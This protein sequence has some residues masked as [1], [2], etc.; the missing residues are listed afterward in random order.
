MEILSLLKN[1]G[2]VW[3]STHISAD[4]DGLGS[5]VAFYHALKKQ[6]IPVKI[7]HNDPYPQRYS[8]LLSDIEVIDSTK[9]TLDIFSANDSIFIFD[10]HDPK[11]CN[12]LFEKIQQAKARVSF[13]DHH[14]LFEKKL[15]SVTYYINEGASCTGEIV[16]E[17]I[18]KM[19]ITLD[20]NI[21]TALYASLLF[22]TQC[23][24]HQ[25]NSIQVLNMAKE[26]V[27]AGADHTQIHT[28]L[29]DNWSVN[30]M[31]YLS[32]LIN[33]VDYKKNDIAII[34]ITK[35]D[36]KEFNLSTDDVSDLVDLFMSVKNLNI[37]IVIREESTN[38]HKLS[39]R[40]R[41]HEI[42]SWAREF[43][44]GGHLYS[45]GAWVHDS[46]EQII[47]KIDTLILKIS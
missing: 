17:L 44:G 31:N 47:N 16:L 36:L 46:I 20:K 18:K 13:I 24:K 15:E 3:L 39:F 19:N 32:K 45:A 40:S 27:A 34:Q 38:F 2:T 35:S 10:T 11:L 6:N 41:S 7:I 4:G 5:E 25:R 12:P 30:K 26:L 1:S 43:G 9:V 29:F 33:Q 42:L 23:F 37:S 21:A 28:Q 8:F 14:I 22:D